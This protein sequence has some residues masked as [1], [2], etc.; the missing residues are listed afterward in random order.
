MMAPYGP[1]PSTAEG[2]LCSARLRAWDARPPTPQTRRHKDTKAIPQ[3][4]PLVRYALSVGMTDWKTSVGLT[5]RRD[6]ESVIP[7]E[8]EGGVEESM[9]W[10][11]C[12]SAPLRFLLCAFAPLRLSVFAFP[13]AGGRI[14]HPAWSKIKRA[15]LAPAACFRRSLFACDRAGRA[16]SSISRP[17]GSRSGA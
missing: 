16:T 15:A 1:Q 8:A 9:G 14:Q 17:S 12:L 4:P 13:W 3:I 11:L 5:G 10:R 2:V 7:S 6:E